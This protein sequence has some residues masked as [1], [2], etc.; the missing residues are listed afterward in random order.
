MWFLGFI[1]SICIV[2]LYQAADVIAYTHEACL[3]QKINQSYFFLKTIYNVVSLLKDDVYISQRS[4]YCLFDTKDNMF[5]TKECLQ[6]GV[7]DM[8]YSVIG[9]HSPVFSG[10]VKRVT[11]IGGVLSYHG[12]YYIYVNINE[13]VNNKVYL[14]VPQNGIFVTGFNLNGKIVKPSGNISCT[15][16]SGTDECILVPPSLPEGA[17]TVII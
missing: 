1:Y 16:F 3:Q 6:Q 13:E 7:L 17:L 10:G 11:D 5:V 8:G 12:H 2:F 9:P 4:G 15:Y 14:E